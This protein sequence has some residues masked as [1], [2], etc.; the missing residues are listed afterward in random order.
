MADRN[1][2]MVQF[3]ELAS[4]FD[5]EVAAPLPAATEGRG[6]DGMLATAVSGIPLA[7]NVQTLIALILALI[8][9]IGPN[10]EAIIAYL[11][12]LGITL[13]PWMVT[14]IKI[15]ISV[16]QGGSEPAIE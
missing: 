13:P 12:T 2:D 5:L 10:L 9:Y 1:F 8:K 4:A 3:E 11:A 15:I 14:V 16:L 6:L 7:I